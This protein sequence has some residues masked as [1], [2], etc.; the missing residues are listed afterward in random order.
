MTDSIMFHDGNR[1]LQD[2]FD[3]RRISDRLEKKL[4]RTAFCACA[5]IA[6]MRSAGLELLDILAAQMSLEEA[7][8][9]IEAAAEPDARTPSTVSAGAR[10]TVRDGPGVS[11]DRQTAA[12]TS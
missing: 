6:E 10:A 8:G 11:G 3:S 5:L 12:E 7:I 4:T 9:K 1:L 2:A